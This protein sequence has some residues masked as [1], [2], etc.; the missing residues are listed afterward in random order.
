MK[1]VISIFL[2]FVMV[3]GLLPVS[4]FA[5]ETEQSLEEIIR[6]QIEAYAKSID[7][8]DADSKAADALAAHGITGKGKKLSVGESHALTATLMNSE[9]VKFLVSKICSELILLIEESETD[10]VCGIGYIKYTENSNYQYRCYQYLYN[11]TATLKEQK[12]KKPEDYI[13]DCGKS[14]IQLNGEYDK[15]LVWIAGYTA[16]DVDL[17][18][19]SENENKTVYNVDVLFM[20]Y[21]DFHTGSGSGFSDIIS[22]IGALLFKEF[23]WEAKCSLQIEI[24]IEKEEEN[25]LLGDTNCDGKITVV[26]ANMVRRAAAKAEELDEAQKLA[27]DVN[28]DGKVTVIDANLIRKY[29]AKLI[30]S[31]SPVT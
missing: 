7:Q 29:A 16:F 31:F 15:S 1:K 4:V 9:L 22:G 13:K 14:V 3:F 5:E 19:V 24:P 12:L 25:Y 11:A 18:L 26:D 10:E 17:K 28:G 6:P 8:K 20:D 30:E 27:A 21:F 2:C 23:Y